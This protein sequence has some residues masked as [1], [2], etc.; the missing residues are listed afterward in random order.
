MLGEGTDH[1]NYSD[2]CVEQLRRLLKQIT[3]KLK[4]KVNRV[5]FRATREF[6]SWASLIPLFPKLDFY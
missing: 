4:L 1:Y 3:K 2:L 6:R 5:T